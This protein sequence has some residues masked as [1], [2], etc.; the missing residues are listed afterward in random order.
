MALKMSK[1]KAVLAIIP[2]L[3]AALIAWGGPW[4]QS[5]ISNFDLLITENAPGVY[6][7][8]CYQ[9][10]NPSVADVHRYDDSQSTSILTIGTVMEGCGHG[11]KV[12]HSSIEMLDNSGSLDSMLKNYALKNPLIHRELAPWE[13]VVGSQAFSIKKGSKPLALVDETSGM[14]ISLDKEVKPPGITLSSRH[15]CGYRE[16]CR[17]NRGDLQVRRWKKAQNRLLPQERQGKDSFPLRAD[18]TASSGSS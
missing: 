2:L 16:L 6:E 13:V 3:L 17:G 9:G 4:L 18:P 10:F 15:P 8:A 7:M 5:R 1:G 14:K 12:D 11:S